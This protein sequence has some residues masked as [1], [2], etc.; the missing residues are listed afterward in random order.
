LVLT[1]SYSFLLKRVVVLD[2]VIL[3]ALYTVRVVA[4]AAAVTVPLSRWFLAF[5]VFLFLSLALLKRLVEVA[6]ASDRDEA[7]VPG[8]GWE[9]G[10]LPILRSLGI[11]SGVV[12][13]LVYCLYITERPTVEELYAHPDLL[14]VGL[15]VI[16]YWLSRVWLL[17]N[18]GEVHDDPVVFAL[19]DRVSYLVLAL[20]VAMV[21]VA[22]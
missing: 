15:P 6:G 5:S 21:M 13:A 10:D 17:A 1:T 16:L 19:R 3:A 8:R 4:G 12:A 9:V 7:S 14:W 11:G 22:A 2:V 20:L 18:R